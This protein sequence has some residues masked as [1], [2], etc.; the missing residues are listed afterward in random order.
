VKK[1]YFLAPVFAFAAAR[2][3]L[4]ALGRTDEPDGSARSRA[5][6]LRTM[7]RLRQFVFFALAFLPLTSAAQSVIPQAGWKLLHVDSQEISCANDGAINAFDDK[8]STFWHTAY[9]GGPN[10]NLPH[11]IQINLGASY[12]LT[13]F[14]YLPRQDRCS[15]GWISKYEFYVSTDGVNWGTA[16]AAGTFNYGA[17]ITGCSGNATVVPAIAVSFPA[18]TGSFVRLRALSEISGNEWSSM[19]ELDVIGAAVAPTTLVRAKFTFDD[20]TPAAGNISVAQIPPGLAPVALGNFPLD[21]TG[22]FSASLTLDPLS[23]YHVQLLDPTGKM[24]QE[25]WSI[26]TSAQVAAAT[27]ATLPNFRLDVVLFKATGAVKSV[28]LVPSP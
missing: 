26:E 20:G 17:A 4:H 3:V 23:Q 28:Q 15:H 24:I 19:A 21:S 7:K 2:R 18:A 5:Q 10:P 14:S 13:G 16:V 6:G 11:D 9:C 1:I 27:I 22:L 25:V 8:P 12:S